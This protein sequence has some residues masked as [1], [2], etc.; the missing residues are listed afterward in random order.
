MANI[1]CFSRVF[2]AYRQGIVSSYH[3]PASFG[4]SQVRWMS[5]V[6]PQFEEAKTRLGALKEDPGNETKLKIYA[7][8]KQAT[9]G[10]VTTKRPGM[11]DFV[12]RAK[13]DAWN[14]LGSMTPEEAQKTYIKLVNSLVGEEETKAAEKAE[15]GQKYNNLIVTCQD[16]LRVITLN[17]PSKMN[18]ITVEMY[19]EWI[20][21]L[22]EARDDPDTVVTAITGAGN[23]YCSGNDLSNF[24]NITP[25]NMHEY[26]KQ[27]GVLLNRFVSAFIDFPKPLVGVINGPAIGVS[28]TVLGLFDAVFA[29]D[30]ATFNTPFSNLG[31]SP[32]GCSSYTFP[33]IMGPTRASELLLFNK[34]ITAHE[35]K[36]LGLVTEVFPDGSFQQE[37]WPKIQSYAKLPLKS[38][39]YSKAL[40]RDVEKDILHK[41][42]DAECDRLVERWVSEDCINAIT[43]F[44]S[45]KNQ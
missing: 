13:W 20:A 21:S 6:S 45:R 16:G 8:F 41:V 19:N 17:R 4:V 18:A 5:G 33:K 1:R 38:L 27:S 31:Q 22:E 24:T 40:T 3:R 29:T 23:Y 39:V 30:K 2:A 26:S 7:L 28:V 35:A 36:D 37:V 11:I 43:R 14:A 15:S 10:P 9:A 34:K 44:F 12:G 42:N 25:D 32:E